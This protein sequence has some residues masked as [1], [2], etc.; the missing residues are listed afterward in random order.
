MKNNRAAKNC[1]EVKHTINIPIR[2]TP[3]IHKPH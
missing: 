2:N 1:D 3:Y